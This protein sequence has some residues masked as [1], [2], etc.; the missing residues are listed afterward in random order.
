MRIGILHARS[1]VPAVEE[2][3]D[4]VGRTSISDIQ[5]NMISAGLASMPDAVDD[6]Q[7]C[8]HS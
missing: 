1:N 3:L 6:R 8:T 4:A 2:V 5:F 7:S